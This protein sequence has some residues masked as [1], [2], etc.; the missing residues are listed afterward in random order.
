M[1]SIAVLV[2]GGAGY[3]GSHTCKALASAGYLPVTLDNLST[4]AAQLVKWGP[5]EVGDIRD[6][7]FTTKI[8]RKYDIKAVVH[9][10]ADAYVGE[11]MIDPLKYY[12]NNVVGMLTLAQAMVQVGVCKIVFSSSCAT[13]GTALEAPIIESDTQLP[14]N[15]YGRTKL[16]C[17][18]I[19][20]DLGASSEVRHVALRYFNAAG[21]DI[22]GETGEIHH[23]ETH[24]IPLAMRAARGSQTLTIFGN[25]FDTPDGTAIRDYIHV[26]DLADAH[27][28]ALKYLIAGGE[29]TA[30]NLGTGTGISVL[31]IIIALEK[32]GHTVPY[33]ISSRRSGDP[34]R[35]V[36]NP[37]KAKAVLNWC[38]KQSSIENIL[39]TAWAWDS[40]QS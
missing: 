22:A 17:E 14:I 27:V 1:N 26:C 31:G 40:R 7:D 12:S 2:T 37:L 18:Q 28:L 29:S 33:R 24:L 10:A 13:Y 25:D 39:S 38:P 5:L 20:R 23:P 16:I 36:A 9:F 6:V 34:A 32:L 11:S 19:L 15:P 4:G 3:I 35:L 21:A 8:L 30:L